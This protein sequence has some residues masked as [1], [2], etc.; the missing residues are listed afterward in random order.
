MSCP[1]MMVYFTDF[2]LMIENIIPWPLPLR[3]N[4][5]CKIISKGPFAAMG[6]GMSSTFLWFAS[7][8][9]GWCLQILLTFSWGCGPINSQYVSLCSPNDVLLNILMLV[10][11]CL[12]SVWWFCVIAGNVPDGCVL[13][14]YI[15]IYTCKNR[16]TFDGRNNDVP[17]SRCCWLIFCHKAKDGVNPIDIVRN[18]RSCYYEP[19]LLMVIYCQSIVV[20]IPRCHSKDHGLSHNFP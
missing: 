6:L 16:Q 11:L 18:P 17:Y 14:I 4:V 12:S 2:I 19:L 10:F 1:K 15:Y 13:C 5:Y 7:Q 20:L 3:F 9:M 8:P